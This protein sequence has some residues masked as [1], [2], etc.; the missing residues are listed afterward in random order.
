MLD[1][2]VLDALA[3][4]EAPLSQLFAHYDS[5][6]IDQALRQQLNLVNAEYAPAPDD[7]EALLRQWER[8]WSDDVFKQRARLL[9]SAELANVASCG[10]GAGRRQTGRAYCPVLAL[11]G[12]HRKLRK[13]PL[14]SRG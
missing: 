3:T 4:I 7:P 1:D 8:E 12:A 14:Q 13:T 11:S 10:T 9:N 2:I 6:R 5:F